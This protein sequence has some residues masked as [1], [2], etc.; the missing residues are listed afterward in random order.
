[1]AR[2]IAGSNDFEGRDLPFTE[3]LNHFVSS[4]FAVIVSCVPGRL[5]AFL[6]ESP[7]S[8]FVLRRS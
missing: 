5:A 6:A 2:V 8:F 1:M 7:T 3:A 4:P